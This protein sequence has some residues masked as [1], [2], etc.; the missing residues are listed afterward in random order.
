MLIKLSEIGA[1]PFVAGAGRKC[2][3]MS[4]AFRGSSRVRA[5]YCFLKGQDPAAQALQASSRIGEKIFDVL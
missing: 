3:N 2:L 5:G 4:P 1:D